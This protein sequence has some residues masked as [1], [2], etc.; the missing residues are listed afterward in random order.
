[1]QS[2]MQRGSNTVFM[3]CALVRIQRQNTEIT[4]Y[5]EIF[6]VNCLSASQLAEFTCAP[7]Q[8]WAQDK[9]EHTLSV[10]C[11]FDLWSFTCLAL[12]Q[13]LWVTINHRD[14]APEKNNKI[15]CS[16]SVFMQST[17]FTKI[18]PQ[19]ICARNFHDSYLNCSRS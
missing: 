2:E 12:P 6:N 7:P 5:V 13:I 9:F 19:E 14:G 17:S 3:F 1:M 4:F 8:R 10:T 18:E 16:I 15:V 11:L